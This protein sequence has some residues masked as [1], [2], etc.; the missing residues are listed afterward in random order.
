MRE[1]NIG[2]ASDFADPG[3]KIIGFDKFE[4][5]VFK[6]DGE[7]YAYLNHCPHMGG[8]ACQGKMIAK[9]EEVIADDHTSKGQMFSKS[10]MHIVCPWHGFEFD[11]RTGRH[12]G[13][14]KARL[15]PIKI[16][17]SGGEV[18][19]TVPDAREHVPVMQESDISVAAP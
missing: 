6:L 10:K 15:R 12:P 11:I 19:L 9:V 18:I 3:K 8:P 7:F 16:A 1:V 4:V 5:G 14:P 2:S 13:N 17:V